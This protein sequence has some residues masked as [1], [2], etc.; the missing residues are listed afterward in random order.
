MQSLILLLSVIS[1]LLT[2]VHPFTN[3]LINSNN[4]RYD[5]TIFSYGASRNRGGGGGGGG[6]WRGGGG[7]SF[8]RPSDNIPI[9]FSKTIKIDPEF[10]TPIADM[11]IS[12]KTKKILTD[13]GFELMTPIQSQSYDLVYSGVDIVG[14]F[15]TTVNSY[16]VLIVLP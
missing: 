9:R 8:Q 15:F 1:C 10:K 2:P 3:T 16:C 6:G 14:T 13:K 12:E 11:N 7:R 4:N 5:T